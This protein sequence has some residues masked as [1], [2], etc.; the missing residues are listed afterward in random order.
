MIFRQI[1]GLLI[2]GPTIY[3]SVA[4]TA[5]PETPF[6]PQEPAP[7]TIKLVDSGSRLDSSPAS[8]LKKCRVILEELV[9]SPKSNTLEAYYAT[10]PELLVKSRIVPVIYLSVPKQAADEHIRK[11]RTELTASKRKRRDIRSLVRR[12][13]QDKPTLRK[14]FLRQGYLFEE[15]PDIAREIVRELSLPDLFDEPEIYLYRNGEILTLTRRDED[16][17]DRDESRAKLLLNDRIALDRASLT[18]PLH[19][20]LGEVR[21]A[22]GAQRTK[23]QVVGEKAAWL[24]L[25]F[26]DGEKRSALVELEDGK[27]KVACITGD[28]ETLV[29]TRQRSDAFWKRHE[30]TIQSAYLI[31]SERPRFDEPTDEAEDVQEDGKLR[32]AWYNAYWRRERTF[33]FREVEYEVFDR[34]GN[35][36]PPQVCIDFVFD[37]WE[38]ASGTWFAMRDQRPRR[39]EGGIDFRAIP[40]LSR[41]YIPSILAFAA[42][43]E[44]PLISYDLPRSDWAPLR[45][46]NHFAQTLA[47][48]ADAIREG[49]ALII[50]GLREEDMAEHYHAALVLET[51]P[52]TG[53]PMVMGDNQGRP[54][55]GSL[56]QVMRR[57][58]KR[59]IKHRLRLDPEKWDIYKAQLTNP[60]SGVPR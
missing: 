15:R 8:V 16:Y 27:T 25:V 38:R 54:H 44:T 22:T 60:D 7:T 52:L 19:L 20:D 55:I 1:H 9:P 41:R 36:I 26:P 33:K 14:L 23:R 47:K 12:H 51:D 58:P 3:L 13:R 21:R 57:A 29:E 46:H 48:H 56:F 53:M 5:K 17:I 49:D 11:I 35:S 37:V 4:C 24:N 34:R 50:H 30:K 59:S 32:L 43:E 6:P 42:K 40:G 45:K 2:L 18:H 28:P 39:T 10:L 31:L